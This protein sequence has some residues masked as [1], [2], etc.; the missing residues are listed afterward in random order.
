MI[1]GMEETQLL[2]YLQAQGACEHTIRYLLEKEMPMAYW[3]S[4]YLTLTTLRAGSL[5]SFEHAVYLLLHPLFVLN[6]PIPFKL[7]TYQSIPFV[8][9]IKPCPNGELLQVA[10][11]HTPYQ[12]LRQFAQLAY[13]YHVQISQRQYRVS[14]VWV[15]GKGE[16]EVS[17]QQV[18]DNKPLAED[19]LPPKMVAVTSFLKE[20]AHWVDRSRKRLPGW[21]SD[22]MGLSQPL[23]KQSL[24]PATRPFE[25]SRA[26]TAHLAWMTHR[27]LY[28]VRYT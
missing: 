17:I 6:K 16:V 25:Q 27:L 20:V 5:N 3:P 28:S 21:Q 12:T 18:N 2:D 13:Q 15:F 9:H 11:Q 24:F 4:L 7:E 22:V 19:R 8:A 26:V 23:I 10:S 14:F 1:G